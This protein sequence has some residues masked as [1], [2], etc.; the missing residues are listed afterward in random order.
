MAPT[1]PNSKVPNSTKPTSSTSTTSSSAA[2][3]PQ[4]S[5][6]EFYHSSSTGHQVGN[7]VSKPTSWHKARETKLNLQLK[8]SHIS[9]STDLLSLVARSKD[10]TIATNIPNISNSSSS[11]SSKNP[12]D[13]TTKAETPENTATENEINKQIFSGCSIYISGMTQPHIGDHAL[14]Q[15]LVK[16]G[17]QVSTYIRATKDT[18]IIIGEEAKVGSGAGGGLGAG[19]IQKLA[20]TR[21]LVGLKFVS[22][23]WV[24]DSVKA[25]RRLSEGAYRVDVLRSRSQRIL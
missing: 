22:V 9:S 15:L 4:R 16:H 19:K 1:I 11:A 14:K 3:H 18:H 13:S 25:G 12:T 6:I 23:H 10:S 21:K 5:L 2:K 7:G 24:L 8:K 17:A 20:Q